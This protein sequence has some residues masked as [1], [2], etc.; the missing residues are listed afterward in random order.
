MLAHAA[1]REGQVAVNNMFGQRTACAT[2]SAV[3][4]HTHPEV[5]SVGMTEEVKRE[6]VEYRK[7]V[8]PMAVAER[9]LVENEGGSGIVKGSARYGEI[10]G[11]HASVIRRASL[12]WR[13]PAWSKTRCPRRRREN[14][15]PSHC[16][17][18][19]AL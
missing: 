8:V 12:L 11:V 7:S 14:V 19:V 6:G 15:F 17:R 5:A 13:P 1:T 10:L 4:H 3:G 18:G 9:F 16:F 2:R